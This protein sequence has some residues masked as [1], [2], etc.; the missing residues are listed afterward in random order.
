MFSTLASV[1]YLEA[2]EVERGQY[3]EPTPM[4]H[5]ILIGRNRT[6]T[7]IFQLQV[8]FWPICG[9]LINECIKKVVCTYNII[10]PLKGRNPCYM[11]RH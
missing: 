8:Q 2:A 3:L 10:Q 4:L 6:R 9:P 1:T 7:Y 5:H 11:L